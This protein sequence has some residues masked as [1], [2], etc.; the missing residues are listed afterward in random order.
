MYQAAIIIKQKRQQ[1][2]L[3][4]Y[5]KFLFLEVQEGKLYHMYPECTRTRT[6]P[7]V[8]NSSGYFAVLAR[9]CPAYTLDNIVMQMRKINR[10]KGY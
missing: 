10:E 5:P 1:L 4:F 6:R 3:S 9:N 2:L 7:K 8:W